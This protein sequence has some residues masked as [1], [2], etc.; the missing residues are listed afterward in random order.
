MLTAADLWANAFKLAA[1]DNVVQESNRYKSSPFLTLQ[2]SRRVWYANGSPPYKDAGQGGQG[3]VTYNQ[4]LRII[5]SME[6]AL[7]DNRTIAKVRLCGGLG[8][9]RTMCTLAICALFSLTLACKCSRVLRT[10]AA[11][12]RVYFHSCIPSPL[13]QHV[14]E[15]P[16][17]ASGGPPRQ[18]EK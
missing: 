14:S 11:C 5:C 13:H 7:N 2:A 17:R 3:A 10:R 15:T 1:Q 6:G 12:W 8:P 16:R 4:Y 9:V 18:C